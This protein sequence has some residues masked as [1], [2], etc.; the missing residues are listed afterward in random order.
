M[1]PENSPVRKVL[2]GNDIETQKYQPIFL[3]SYSSQ[4]TVQD[5]NC[6]GAGGGGWDGERGGVEVEFIKL[7]VGRVVRSVLKY[8]AYEQKDFQL[9]QKQGE[10]QGRGWMLKPSERALVTDSVPWRC[11]GREKK[12]KKS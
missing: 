9:H 8:S 7:E 2:A 4:K 3:R 10:M 12:R 11:A 6:T 5:C 1:N